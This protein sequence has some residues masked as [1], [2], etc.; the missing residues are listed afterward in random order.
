MSLTNTQAAENARL[1]AELT[2]LRATIAYLQPKCAE[3]CE[4]VA[5]ME[6]TIAKLPKDSEGKPVV[7]RQ[8]VWVVCDGSHWW[9]KAEM[10]T[11][12]GLYRAAVVS[13]DGDGNWLLELL[14]WQHEPEWWD[15]PVHGTKAAAEAARATEGSE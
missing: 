3:L 8:V 14:G 2:E 5:E 7:F 11:T 1:E 4:K 13:N 12:A 9:L 15:G 6:A 10:W